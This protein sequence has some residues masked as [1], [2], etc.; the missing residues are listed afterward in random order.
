MYPGDVAGR[1]RGDFVVVEDDVDQQPVRKDGVHVEPVAAVCEKVRRQH[2]VPGVHDAGNQHPDHGHKH[3]F[4]PRHEETKGKK[5]EDEGKKTHSS[6]S[7]FPP[8]REGA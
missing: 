6:F 5:K 2:R 4:P 7:F 1:G 3:L 8:G